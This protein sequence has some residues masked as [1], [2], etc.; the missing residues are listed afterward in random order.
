MSISVARL[1]GGMSS[2]AQVS[3]EGVVSTRG[4]RCL[5]RHPAG[6]DG[7]VPGGDF[8]RLEAQRAEDGADVGAV[9]VGVVD[10]LGEEDGGGDGV[11]FALV[12]AG[13][14]GALFVPVGGEEL[15]EG[16]GEGGG[17]F[18]EHVQADGAVFAPEETGL[19][20]GQAV[21]V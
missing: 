2:E 15:F 21:D 10:G 16:G 1:S 5:Q 19:E 3:G 7:V 9:L 8:G 20:T 17:A 13:L 12:T 18:G 4:R 11:E 14:A 6:G